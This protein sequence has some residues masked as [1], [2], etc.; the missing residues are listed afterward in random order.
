MGMR[1]IVV[2][3]PSAQSAKMSL[4]K[5]VEKDDYD[6]HE[7]F[8]PHKGLHRTKKKADLL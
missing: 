4:K 6:F 8:D 3:T 7:I 1:P 5:R 2:A